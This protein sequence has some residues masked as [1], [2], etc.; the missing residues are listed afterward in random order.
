MNKQ[1]NA[2]QFLKEAEDLL[3]QAQA[4]TSIPG[5]QIVSISSDGTR[6]KDFP[7]AL[8]TLGSE[9]VVLR[10]DLNLSRTDIRESLKFIQGV[11]VELGKQA[12]EVMDEKRV[13][14]A[15]IYYRDKVPA[16]IFRAVSS[17]LISCGMDKVLW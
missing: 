1:E 9:M 10:A 7:V 6:L 17:A 5:V 3:K 14:N 15:F 2:T 4:V 16:Q 13:K 8:R 11:R 12:P